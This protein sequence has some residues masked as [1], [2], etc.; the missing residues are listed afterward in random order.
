MVVGDIVGDAV[1]F[2]VGATVVTEEV[3]EPAG[4]VGRRS[5]RRCRWVGVVKADACA[6]RMPKSECRRCQPPACCAMVQA[7]RARSVDVAAP[8]V[9]VSFALVR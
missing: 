4:A 6:A 9:G 5:R 2:D 1:G 3:G 8:A 7:Q